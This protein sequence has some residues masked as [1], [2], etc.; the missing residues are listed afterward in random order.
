MKRKILPMDFVISENLR[1]RHLNSAQL[2]DIGLI[3][4]EHKKEEINKEKSIKAK[5]QRDRE[6]KEKNGILSPKIKIQKSESRDALV[7]TA[8]ELHISDKTLR[9]TSKNWIVF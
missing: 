3:I 7:E 2:A 8:K 4:W 1:R 6:I 5:E 9:K